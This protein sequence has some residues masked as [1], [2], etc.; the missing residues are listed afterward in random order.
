MNP[1]L[2][3]LMSIVLL[4]C[5]A[6]QA[7]A[8]AVNPLTGQPLAFETTQRRLEQ[9]RLETQLLE[10]E[11]KQAAIRNNMSLAPI[12]RGHEE[13][14]LQAEMFGSA[15]SGH[16]TAPGA[17]AAIGGGGSAAAT[18]TPR[19]PSRAAAPL[20]SAAPP[21]VASALPAASS[22]AP[23]VVPAQGPQV[24]AILRNGDQRRA[25]VQSGTTTTA[26]SEGDDW[27]GRRI[28][29]IT[30]GSVT[31]DGV[32]IDL[33]RNPAVVVASDRRPPPGQPVLLQPQRAPGGSMVPGGST[34]RMPGTSLGMAGGAS[35]TAASALQ[36]FPP[37]PPL[38][39]VP[40]LGP[41]DPRN[42][43]SA[44]AP[45][46]SGVPPMSP[47]LAG[48]PTG[49]ASPMPPRIMPGAVTPAVDGLR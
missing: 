15:L 22:M 26:V 24:L 42:P 10:E 48:S 6:A 45:Q 43:L 20:P 28:D 44:L 19:R 5:A 34:A 17:G 47:G 41:V 30:D 38:P 31:I 39:S 2:P 23:V 49:P 29:A 4:A 32:V 16:A 11:A 40:V 12:R 9:M 7:A 18:R 8:P 27:M 14:R 33:P 36:P 21:V 37:L 13:R 3:A 46:P 1:V 25:I 35:T